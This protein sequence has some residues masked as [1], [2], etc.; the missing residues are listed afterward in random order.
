MPKRTSRGGPPRPSNPWLIPVLLAALV[1]GLVVTG[2][3]A[4]QVWLDLTRL[5]TSG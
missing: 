1:V 2:F 4:Y 3:Y 5:P